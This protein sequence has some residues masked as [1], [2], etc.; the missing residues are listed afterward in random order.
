MASTIWIGDIHFGGTNVPVKLHTA[1]SQNLTQF[2]LLHKTDRVQLRQQ[3]VCA[4]E[5]TP[6][7]AEEQV[8][9]FKVDERKYV[10]IDPEEIEAAE[11]ESSR[12]IE[13]HEF[14]KPGEIDPV[15]IERTYFLEPDAVSKSYSA[16][17]AALKEMNAEGICTWVMRKRAYFGAIQSTGKTLR[18]NTLR[19]A[20]EVIA[21]ETLELEKFTLSEKELNI[22]SELINKLTVKFEPQKYTNEHRKKLQELIAKKARGEKITLLKP[23]QPKTTAPDK[24]LEALEKSLKK[25]A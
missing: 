18:L 8:K 4:F 9:G 12:M 11:P 7:P 13:V 6:V 17:A 15:F 19:Y 24:L 5:K 21:A 1:V 20:D 25:A 22:G 23:K 2:H 3:M 10:L 16:L 14:V